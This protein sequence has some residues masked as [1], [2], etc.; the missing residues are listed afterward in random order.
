M[1][2]NNKKTVAISGGFDPIH[3]GHI[4]M[5]R[6]AANYGEVVVILNT[7][8]WLKKKKGYSFM[9]FIQRKEIIESIK[10]VKTVVAAE[11]EDGTV[12]K[13]LEHIKP[14]YFAN[15]GDRI[16][17]NTPEIQI[18]KKYEIKLLWNVG[19][20]KIQSSSELVENRRGK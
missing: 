20:G 3:I 4:R 17:T 2:R 10:G 13:S 5:I 16:N 19:G 6:D 14:D 18:C 8:E 1:T 7:D 15:G 11:D 12:C 9:P